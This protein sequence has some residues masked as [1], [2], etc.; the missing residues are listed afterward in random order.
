[1]N[2]NKTNGAALKTVGAPTVEEKVM[3]VEIFKEIVEGAMIKFIS[4]QYDFVY[5]NLTKIAGKN[6]G[7]NLF[8]ELWSVGLLFNE[9]LIDAACDYIEWWCNGCGY[10]IDLYDW[11]KEND[12]DLEDMLYYEAEQA[13][14]YWIKLLEEVNLK[15]ENTSLNSNLNNKDSGE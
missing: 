9:Y 6:I 1:M 7:E 3:T 5:D 11:C 4:K 12:I 2:T 13:V 8:A 15:Y 10:D 14:E